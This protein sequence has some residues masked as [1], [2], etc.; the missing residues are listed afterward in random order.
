MKARARKGLGIALLAGAPVT[1]GVLY[2][3]GVRLF[4]AEFESLSKPAGNGWSGG[5]V[6]HVQFHWPFFALFLVA[7]FG[8]WLLTRSRHEEP[9]A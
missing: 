6:G 3:L 9:K 4:S 7:L 5:W 8:V 2:L 1:G